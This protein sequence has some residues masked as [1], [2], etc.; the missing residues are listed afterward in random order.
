[1]LL[2]DKYFQY[3]YNVQ[4]VNGSFRATNEQL[5][6]CVDDIL[7]WMDMKYGERGDC[8]DEINPKS[9]RRTYKKFPPKNG[10]N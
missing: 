8:E 7:D 3:T 10:Q 6:T 2:F 1:M 9:N 5:E 4:C